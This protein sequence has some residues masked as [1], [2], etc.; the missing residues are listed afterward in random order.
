VIR[1]HREVQAGLTA[2]SEILARAYLRLAEKRRTVALSGA[3]KVQKPLE[4]CAPESPDEV[5]ESTPEATR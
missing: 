2:L 4:V 1:Q 5:G 3:K